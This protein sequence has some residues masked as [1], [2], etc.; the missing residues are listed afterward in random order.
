MTLAT[1]TPGLLDLLDAPSAHA[2]LDLFAKRIDEHLR[3]G[4][5]PYQTWL[6]VDGTDPHLL[7]AQI[8]KLSGKRRTVDLSILSTFDALQTLLP[9]RFRSTS[10]VR[11]RMASEA[12]RIA[13]E[14][15]LTLPWGVTLD[16]LVADDPDNAA[17]A[18]Y[19]VGLDSLGF[20]HPY[21]QLSRLTLPSGVKHIFHAN[22]DKVPDAVLTWF[23]DAI[24]R[25][26]SI[27]A[28]CPDRHK[29]N[30]RLPPLSMAT[31]VPEPRPATT[32]AAV[33]GKRFCAFD[34]PAARSEAL[35]DAVATERYQYVYFSSESDLVEFELTCLVR[36]V[37]FTPSP[38]SSV[39]FSP[40]LR[41][42]YAYL[43]WQLHSS[44]ASLEALFELAGGSLRGWERFAK[45][46]HLPADLDAALHVIERVESDDR[47]PLLVRSLAALGRQW[48]FADHPSERLAALLAW[49][50]EYC[51]AS[52]HAD[53]SMLSEFLSNA[54][55]S[56]QEIHDSACHILVSA[57][58]RGPV[59]LGP[60]DTA[61]PLHSETVVVPA[62]GTSHES[63]THLT[64]PPRA[65]PAVY[66]LKGT[67][68]APA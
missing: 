43:D 4:A 20:R 32:L 52:L 18:A 55:V 27:T 49:A 66:T 39:L 64:A 46:H 56:L 28:L 62:V 24:P 48:A 23:L 13:S 3:A 59:L 37:F 25:G 68:H 26:T 12:R 38:Q 34:S 17:V 19:L 60:A 16:E 44:T 9:P 7:A 53:L 1:D 33:N 6:V 21:Q 31:F 35:L 5:S 41:L 42:L 22:L 61:P 15:G 14:C 11:E 2:R 63:F 54:A 51:P 30:R 29:L 57:G 50:M 67:C 10:V 65:A 58:R 8:A 36:S 47:T 45:R 40:A